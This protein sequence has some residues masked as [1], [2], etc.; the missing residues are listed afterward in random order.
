MNT[1]TTDQFQKIV[2]RPI[3]RAL[4]WCPVIWVLSFGI[5]IVIFLPFCP[6]NLGPLKFQDLMF[7]VKNYRWFVLPVIGTV[8]FLG[9]SGKIEPSNKTNKRLGRIVLMLACFWIFLETS[10]AMWSFFS[11]PCQI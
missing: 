10:V 8:I 9:L 6:S 7:V 4:L 5:W 11:A 2:V 1:P 3:A